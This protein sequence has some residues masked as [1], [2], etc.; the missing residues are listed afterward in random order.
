MQT[1]IASSA[2]LLL[3]LSVAGCVAVYPELSPPLRTPPVDF[4][5]VPPPPPDVFYFR[6]AGADIPTRTRD[7]RHWDAV[8][9]EAPDPFAKLLLNGKEIIVTSV[10]GDSIRPTWPDQERANYRFRASDL[11]SIEVWDSNPLNNH[12][13]CRQ[14]VPSL[15]DFVQGDEP[16]MEIECDNGGRVRLIVQPAHAR[17]GLGLFYELRTGGAFITRVISESP[18]GRAGLHAGDEIVK[19]QDQPVDKMEDGKLQS[20]INANASV[21][22]KLAVQAASGP[23]REVTIRDGAIYPIAGEGIPLE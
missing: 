11:L 9:G 12:P 19:A 22:V 6:F 23:L 16:Y 20:L 17:L 21:G 1:W 2:L 14:K 15:H 18:A 10:E 3:G 5:L 7:G 8:G 13:I 4:R